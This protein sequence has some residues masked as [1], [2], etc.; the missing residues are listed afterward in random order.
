MSGRHQI[1]YSLIG[2][3]R[4]RVAFYKLLFQ[5]QTPSATQSVDTYDFYHLFCLFVLVVLPEPI[6]ICSLVSRTILPPGACAYLSIELTRMLFRVLN[7][8]PGLGLCLVIKMESL[9]AI[10]NHLV[11]TWECPLDHVFVDETSHQL[12]H[13]QGHR[14]APIYLPEV[15]CLAVQ[16][17]DLLHF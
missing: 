10:F 8:L 5:Y 4:F 16:R 9:I 1:L 14:I 12:R 11:Q 15:E 3:L 13:P 7:V 6:S 17:D 2:Y